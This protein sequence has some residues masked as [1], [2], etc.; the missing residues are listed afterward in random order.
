M[1]DVAFPAGAY[2][3]FLD[4]SAEGRDDYRLGLVLEPVREEDKELSCDVFTASKEPLHFKRVARK[5]MVLDLS[6]VAE[7][8]V[9]VVESTGK[10]KKDPELVKMNK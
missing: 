5:Q 2:L 3:A 6:V 8:K 1:G 9:V 10:G 4:P 7:V